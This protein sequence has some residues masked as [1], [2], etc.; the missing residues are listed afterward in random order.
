MLAATMISMPSGICCMT[1]PE[2]AIRRRDDIRNDLTNLLSS[3]K[4]ESK[5]D[6][7][8]IKPFITAVAALRAKYAVANRKLRLT[9]EKKI[10][11]IK[12]QENKCPL[13]GD[14]IYIADDHEVDHAIP[15]GARRP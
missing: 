7:T 1:F 5:E 9:R 11:L 3:M 4:T 13:C 2:V 12:R 6:E 15:I 10:D 14:T 8:D